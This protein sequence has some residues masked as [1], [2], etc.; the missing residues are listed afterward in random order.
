MCINQAETAEVNDQM[1]LTASIYK[2]ARYILVD[3]GEK[4][5]DSALAVELLELMEEPYLVRGRYREQHRH[6]RANSFY[7]NLALPEKQDGPAVRD[8]PSKDSLFGH[9]SPGLGALCFES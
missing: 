4:I 7:L 8:S 1:E 2:T 9:P 3:L 5:W 6:C